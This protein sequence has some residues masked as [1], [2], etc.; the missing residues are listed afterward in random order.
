MV[1]NKGHAFVLALLITLLL[2][3]N[4]FLIKNFNHERRENVIISRVIDGDTL[5]LNDG[6]KIRLLNINSPEK[7]DPGFDLSYNLLKQFENKTIEIEPISEDLYSR[8]L[9]RMYSPE[10]VNLE[11]VKKG[12]A[13]KFLVSGSELKDFAKAESFAISNSLGI[14]KKSN[15]YGC[16]TAEVDEHNEIISIINS[17]DSVNVNNWFL[18]DESTKQYEFDDINLGLVFLHSGIGEDNSTDLFW[19]S[20]YNV[21][22]NDRDSIYLFDNNGKLVYYTTYGY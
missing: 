20:K 14:W 9:V 2:A 15:F 18:K 16:F 12:F 21:L 11:L 19:N 4:L 5:E 22:N 1:M 17:C 13:S 8:T 6:R 10:Y 7:S 3:I